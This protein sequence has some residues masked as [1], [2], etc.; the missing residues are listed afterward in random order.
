MICF[1]DEMEDK[2]QLLYQIFTLIQEERESARHHAIKLYEMDEID[3]YDIPK[4]FTFEFI[5]DLSN[6]PETSS[7]T[8]LDKQTLVVFDDFLTESEGSQKIIG[9]YF[10]RGRKRNIS[11][12]Y[13]SQ[14]W[15]DVPKLIRKNLSHI[16][17]FKISDREL[18]QVYQS[19]G[20]TLSKDAFYNY[21]GRCTGIPYG[22]C[23]IDLTQTSLGKIFREGFDE[24]YVDELYHE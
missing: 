4:P 2:Y 3:E 24:P 6:V 14:S 7:F 8:D 22:F 12:F 18:P 10:I 11:T 13:I 15:F 17:M 1:K 23:Y 16:I 21:Y 5:H 19:F 9:E 20:R